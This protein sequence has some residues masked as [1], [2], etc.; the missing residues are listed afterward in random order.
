LKTAF[1]V[2]WIQNL[3]PKPFCLMEYDESGLPSHRKAKGLFKDPLS[4]SWVST[5]QSETAFEH[6]SPD[7]HYYL[8]Y[9]IYYDDGGII[10][11]SP[12][13]GILCLLP[14]PSSLQDPT[15]A[16]SNLHHCTSKPFCFLPVKTM[17]GSAT[18]QNPP[19]RVPSPSRCKHQ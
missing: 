3:G 5:F 13:K 14:T 10:N 19:H 8:I 9:N 17:A 12:R 11:H 6:L 2:S 15:T 16:I 4:V 7:P 18:Q 1:Q